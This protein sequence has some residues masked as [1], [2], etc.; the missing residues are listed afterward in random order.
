MLSLRILA[1]KTNALRRA[2]RAKNYFEESLRY[3]DSVRPYRLVF[4]PI[5]YRATNDVYI[6][7]FLRP[8]ATVLLNIVPVAAIQSLMLRTYI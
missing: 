8:F 6:P 7:V 2:V 1:D 5:E 4:L 3:R